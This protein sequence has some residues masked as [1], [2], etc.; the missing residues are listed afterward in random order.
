M[1]HERMGNIVVTTKIAINDKSIYFSKISYNAKL[2]EEIL[3][4]AFSFSVH[5][6]EH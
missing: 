1:W 6:N 3:S 4:A 5:V 2:I